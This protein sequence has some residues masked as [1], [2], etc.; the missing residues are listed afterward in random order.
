MGFR[1]ELAVCLLWELDSPGGGVV[2]LVRQGAGGFLG[3]GAGG[4]FRLFLGLR[5][6]V[7]GC[8]EQVVQAYS[9]G[10]VGHQHQADDGHHGVVLPAGVVDMKSTAHD[11]TKYYKML[12]DGGMWEGVQAIPAYAVDALVGRGFA[13]GKFPT[14]CYGIKKRTFAGKIIG[15]HTGALHGTS[16]AAGFVEGGYSA[17]VLC[18]LGEMD[19]DPFIWAAYNL[20]L[21][22][23]PETDQYL[24]DPIDR[25]FSDPEALTGDFL[26]AE[27][28]PSLVK[29]SLRDGHPVADYAGTPVRLLYCG[30]SRF[31][32][33]SDDENKKRVNTLEFFIRGAGAWAVR[34]GSRIYR[35]MENKS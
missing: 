1:H 12:C 14:Y 20:I 17:A 29:V 34:C 30:N 10:A 2:P 35:R 7:L 21:G 23:P 19:P 26:A 15:E 8:S 31:S 5:L 28:Q 9:P 16:T 24:F 27:G 18:N 22:L 11:I 32:A 13:A 25:E 33:V 3:Q 4:A 6:D